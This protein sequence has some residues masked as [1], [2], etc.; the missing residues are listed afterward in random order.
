[1]KFIFDP[2][3]EMTE[4]ETKTLSTFFR[5][6]DDAC[7][8]AAKCETCILHNLCGE[9]ENAPSYLSELFETLGIF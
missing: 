5:A 9:Y 8:N 4:Q 2:K 1:M 6:V 7:H 3:I